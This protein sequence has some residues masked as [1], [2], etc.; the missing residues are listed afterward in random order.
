MLSG[1]LF[2]L[3]RP[4]G[5]SDDY[6]VE[7][8]E[9]TDMIEFYADYHPDLSPDEYILYEEAGDYFSPYYTHSIYINMQF[10]DDYDSEIIDIDWN[11]KLDYL[12]TNNP[13]GWI[14][15]SNETHQD[16]RQLSDHCPVTVEL[17][18]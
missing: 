11:R 3:Y 9:I 13:T 18:W 8:Y 7:D 14:A 4:E 6:E 5:L 12:F 15:G 17:E 2:H 16:T 10:E 1:S